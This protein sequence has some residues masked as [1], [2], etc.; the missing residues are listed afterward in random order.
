M[1]IG[2]YV[3]YNPTKGV[4]DASKLSYTSPVGS[5]PSHGNGHSKQTFSA[6][7]TIEWRVLSKNE[8]TGEVVLISAEPIDPNDRVGFIMQ[9]AIGYLYGEQ[10]LNEI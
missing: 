7:N 4:T 9:G 5:G 3:A 1:Q 2:D 10:E 8:T 6:N